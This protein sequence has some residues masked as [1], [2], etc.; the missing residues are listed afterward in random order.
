M[1]RSDS[2]ASSTAETLRALNCTAASSIVVT[3]RTWYLLAKFRVPLL[4]VTV[5][6]TQGYGG[7]LTDYY[8]RVCD[9]LFVYGTLRS[10]FDNPYARLLRERSVFVGHA[11]V[12]G[13]TRDMGRYSAF[14]PGPEGE[15][16]G[17]LYRLETPVATLA[18]LDDYEG[19]E[20]ERVAIDCG[21]DGGTELAWIYQLR[22]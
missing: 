15:V 5:R 22:Q 14:T 12:R 18:T 8:K 1:Q 21:F 9:L 16:K 10:G 19:E 7:S 2:W 4:S 11:T 20:Y 13:T 3:F 17:E 6:K